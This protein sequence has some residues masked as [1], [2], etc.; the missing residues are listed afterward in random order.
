MITSEQYTEPTID[1]LREGVE[2]IPQSEGLTVYEFPYWGKK[3]RC[4]V[5]TA[6]QFPPLLRW[7]LSEFPADLYDEMGYLNNDGAHD[8]L[9]KSDY[10]E[11]IKEHY[12]D[13]ATT[14]KVRHVLVLES[15]PKSNILRIQA[16]VRMVPSSGDPD[17][18]FDESSFPTGDLFVNPNFPLPEGI[19]NR[20]VEELSRLVSISEVWKLRRAWIQGQE[21]LTDEQ[22]NFLRR[23]LPDSAISMDSA[24]PEKERRRFVAVHKMVSKL[25]RQFPLMLL[26]LG[27]DADT[28]RRGIKYFIGNLTKKQAG[29]FLKGRGGVRIQCLH[30]EIVN[31]ES[32]AVQDVFHPYMETNNGDVT[33]FY[34]DPRTAIDR[35]I[36]KVGV[37]MRMAR[38]ILIE[39][40]K[41]S[42]QSP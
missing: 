31:W 3:F 18:L 26:M 2:S 21:K 5:G 22:L 10:H 34:F 12:I 40:E 8:E 1:Q 32:S 17:A 25:W 33:P 11:M 19:L 36:G 37:I 16:M 29:D 42:H 39:R 24:Q 38:K 30:N 20:D 4:F 14:S 23:Y 41:A 6:D 27:V 28:R 9:V 7:M 13:D 35:A 15:D